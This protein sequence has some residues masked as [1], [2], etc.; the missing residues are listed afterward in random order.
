MSSNTSIE[1]QK[2]A[3]NKRLAEYGIFDFNEPSIVYPV[4]QGINL[5]TPVEAASRMLVLLTVAFSAYSFNET[6]KL[7]DWI[8]KE[9]LWKA[10]SEKEKEF[11][12]SPDPSEETKA[13][14][15]WR[16]E[17][18][19]MLAWALQIVETLPDPMEECSEELV[20][21]FLSN[22]PGI[23]NTTN[24]FFRHLQFRPYSEMVNEYLFYT[25]A[26]AYFIDI[27]E[28]DLANTSSINER[29]AYERGLILQW[30]LG[31]NGKDWDLLSQ[32]DDE[33]GL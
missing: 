27:H 9:D 4:E 11:F 30:L 1:K 14:L 16:F 2:Q 25:T 6:D 19:Y 17:C 22:T 5:A 28:K 7:T 31:L 3:I 12:R 15:S 29:A 18:A 24:E 21:E 10:V 32:P 33:S 23:G 26:S 8:K 13:A 20:K